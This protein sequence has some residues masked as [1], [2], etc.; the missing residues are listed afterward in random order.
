MSGIEEN[1]WDKDW[2]SAQPALEDC[3]KEVESRSRRDV[4]VLRSNQLDAQILDSEINGL[5]SSQFMRAFAFFKAQISQV[6]TP[7]SISLML[8]IK[9]NQN[10]M[11]YWIF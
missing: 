1:T 2:K 10:L 6:H 7:N 9:L 8:S 5:L 11:L 3:K 4:P